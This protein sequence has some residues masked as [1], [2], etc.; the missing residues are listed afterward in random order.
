M[1]IKRREF[2]YKSALGVGGIVLSASLPSFAKSDTSTFNPYEIIP[3]GKTGLKV[4]RICMGTG[5]NGNMR[6]S[7]QTRLGRKNFEALLRGGYDR[8]VRMFDLADLYGSHSYLIPALKGIP[9]ENFIIATKI[10]WNDCCL[11]ERERPDVDVVV[12][13]FLKEIQTDYLDLVLLHCVTSGN[14]P[15][16]LRKQMDGLSKL[17]EK[18]VVRAVGLSCHSLPALEAAA[19]EPWVDSVHARINPY[20]VNM[21][22][23]PI[24][25]VPVLKKIHDAGKGVVGMKILG[26]GEFSRSEEMRDISI[27]YALHLGCVDVLNV[28]FENSNQID[29]FAMRVR[30][31]P[32]PAIA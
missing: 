29:D 32:R 8:G 6:E 17:K 24:Q 23:P 31:V 10:W 18:G 19:N 3:L 16:E 21:D 12:A 2:I 11:P 13:R 4:S 15:Q 1:R 28:G 26:A 20:N 14:W 22:A 5:A 9:R 7:N 25:V 27:R 30:K